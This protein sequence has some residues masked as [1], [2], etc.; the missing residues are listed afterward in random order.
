MAHEK[1]QARVVI[2][3]NGPYIV[4]GGVPLSKQTIGS[5]D[6]R[7]FRGVAGERNLSGGGEIRPMPVRTFE[8][9]AV[10]RQHPCQDRF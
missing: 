3:E 10:L 7:R 5:S 1:S 4:S 6:K 8:Q 9:K 2:A